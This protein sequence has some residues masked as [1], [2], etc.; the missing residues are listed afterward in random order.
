MVVGVDQGPGVWGDRA[1]RGGQF[2][3]LPRGGQRVDEQGRAVADH[4]GHV[5]LELRVAQHVD[6]VGDLGETR[7]DHDW[8]ALARNRWRS[9]NM[10][11][12]RPSATIADPSLTLISKSSRRPST[13]A[14]WAV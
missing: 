10:R 5:D 14:S 7:G 9:T 11:S 13:L 12:T 6:S 4:Q 3:G 8:K 1:C 2:E